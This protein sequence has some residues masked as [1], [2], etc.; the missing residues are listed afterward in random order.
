M[1]S[2]G[3]QRCCSN[4]CEL[5][6]GL[7]VCTGD[8]CELLEGLR[9]VLMCAVQVKLWSGEGID[10]EKERMAIVVGTPPVVRQVEL[11]KKVP[12]CVSLWLSVAVSH[13]V[14]RCGSLLLCGSL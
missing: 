9:C 1:S 6:E 2:R 10:F 3:W 11:M 12:C 14:S 8:C 13:Y 5:L 7:R 4:C